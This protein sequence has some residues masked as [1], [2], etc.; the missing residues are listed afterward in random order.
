VMLNSMRTVR[1][2]LET[3]GWSGPTAQLL[4]RPLAE[5]GSSDQNSPWPASGASVLSV[6]RAS[7]ASRRSDARSGGSGSRE[8]CTGDEFCCGGFPP[9]QSEMI[10]EWERI[11]LDFDRRRVA[12]ATCHLPACCGKKRGKNRTPP[13]EPSGS[14][15]S[16][17]PRSRPFQGRPRA[18]SPGA[19]AETFASRFVA[20][21]K[22]PDPA[23]S[24]IPSV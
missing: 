3:I 22:R 23:A 21:G 17:L 5:S 9:E 11:F 6:C 15:G 19:D 8:T 4:L 10:G 16:D 24:R 18:R 14:P 1:W 20:A 2:G 7:G 13:D 12:V